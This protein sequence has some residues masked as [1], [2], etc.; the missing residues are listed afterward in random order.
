MRKRQSSQLISVKKFGLHCEDMSTTAFNSS[1]EVD[2][3]FHYQNGRKS[4]TLAL[5]IIIC[6]Q[7]GRV[8]HWLT[9]LAVGSIEYD[10]WC[11]CELT[12]DKYKK[13]RNS[14]QRSQVVERHISSSEFEDTRWITSFSE[15][16]SDW[17]LNESADGK[18]ATWRDWLSDWARA[19]E[20]YNLKSTAAGRLLP[21]LDCHCHSYSLPWTMPPFL[22]T[23]L[24]FP[25]KWESSEWEHYW[26]RNWLIQNVHRHMRER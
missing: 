20:A 14:T 2:L 3:S 11:K 8:D 16:L 6:S 22:N 18:W 21:L 24:S 17:L 4:W 7:V 26:E 12:Q 25:C 19:A 9:Y 13:W 23:V 1:L 5:L 10:V 15:W